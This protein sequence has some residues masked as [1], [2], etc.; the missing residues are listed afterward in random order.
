MYYIK[1]KKKSDT[2]TSNNNYDIL[3]CRNGGEMV[4]GQYNQSNNKLMLDIHIFLF[5]IKKGA[6][7]SKNFKKIFTRTTGSVT[8]KKNLKVKF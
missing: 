4:I 1:L 2:S 7:F 3:I 6:E 8:A 5:V